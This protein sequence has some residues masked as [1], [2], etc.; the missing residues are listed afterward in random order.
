MEDTAHADSLQYTLKELRRKIADSEAQIAKLR[1]GQQE[2]PLS[3]AAQARVITAA[4]EEVTN[5]EPYLPFAGS[6]LPSLIAM[7]KTYSAVRETESLIK[8]EEEQRDAESKRLEADRAALKDQT[9]LT[10]ALRER[11]ESL[12]NDL[13]AN[14]DVREDQVL[15]EKMQEL[16]SKTDFY[17]NEHVRL[18]RALRQFVY[19]HLAS[20]LA[21]EEVGGPVVGDVLEVDPRDL[22][23]GLSAQGN[24]KRSAKG[25]SG[26]DK[27][28]RRIDDIYRPDRLGRKEQSAQDDIEEAGKELLSLVQEMFE[29]LVE[30]QGDNSESY[31]TVDRESAAT[32]FLIRSKVAQFHPKD[33]W[34]MRIIDFGRELDG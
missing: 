13:A 7:R 17:K 30:A 22:A 1:K 10:E 18:R 21:A 19:E 26:S 28:Q 4:F 12:R 25:M 5:A 27:R 9:L 24:L 33:A 32:R 11:I 8:G 31:I 14:A 2:V 16:R 15:R 23:A 34:R 29:R 6:V 3:P 20:L